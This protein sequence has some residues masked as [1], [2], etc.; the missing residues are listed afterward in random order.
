ML[1]P[2][3]AL[4]PCWN[5]DRIFAPCWNGDADSP[6][7]AQCLNGVPRAGTGTKNVILTCPVLE[8]GAPFWNWTYHA[9]T[10][11][12]SRNPEFALAPLWHQS[13]HGAPQTGTSAILGHPELAL[14]RYISM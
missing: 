1:G 5:G 13:Q 8:L 11:L 14:L 2:K 12:S 7:E 10:G 6:V 3:K 9:G 4:G